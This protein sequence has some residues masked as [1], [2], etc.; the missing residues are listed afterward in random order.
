MDWNEKLKIYDA[1]VNK[2]LR[3]ERKVKIMIFTSANGYM[4]FILNK[5]G[6]IGIRFSKVTQ[7]KILNSFSPPCLSLIES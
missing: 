3:F 2:Y 4:F 1:L 6:K 7:E 5:T